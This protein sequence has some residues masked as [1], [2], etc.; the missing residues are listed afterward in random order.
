[1]ISVH[2]P[3]PVVFRLYGRISPHPGEIPRLVKVE[4]HYTGGVVLCSSCKCEIRGQRLL[5]EDEIS[6]LSPGSGK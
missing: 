6:P 3:I 5:L 1:M 2:L 4:L